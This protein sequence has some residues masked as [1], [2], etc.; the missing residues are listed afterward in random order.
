MVMANFTKATATKPSLLKRDE[1]K[2][3]FHE[4]GHALHAIFGATEIA[5]LSGTHTKR[6]FVELPSQML[7]EW[8]HDKDILKKVSR[9]YI[10]GATTP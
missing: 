3:F 4:F 2:T 10:T 8:L 9:H 5:S 1:V 6:D 7:E